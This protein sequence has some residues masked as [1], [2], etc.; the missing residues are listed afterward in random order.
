MLQPFP[1]HWLYMLHGNNDLNPSPTWP[2]FFQQRT[3]EP[4]RPLR[5]TP[6]TKP[7]EAPGP[8]RRT[9]DVVDFRFSADAIPWLGS[10]LFTKPEHKCSEAQN[11][12]GLSSC[13]SPFMTTMKHCAKEERA[14]GLFDD[15]LGGVTSVWDSLRL[16]KVLEDFYILGF[17]GLW[18]FR[19]RRP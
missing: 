11:G 7:P 15:V 13:I 4:T 12:R 2:L 16:L 19:V 1:L 14:A 9:C 18:G 17:S 3:L 10:G 8:M 5:Q 6:K